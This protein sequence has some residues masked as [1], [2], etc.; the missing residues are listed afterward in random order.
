MSKLTT[1]EL[2]TRLATMERAGEDAIP[3]GWDIPD[4]LHPDYST[5]VFDLLGLPAD[6]WDHDTESGFCRDGF[7][8]YWSE[9]VEGRLAV[10]E[11][12]CLCG[13]RMRRQ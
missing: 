6:T 10:G 5:L 1:I 13:E 3:E 8:G 7:Y 2:V 12:I 9:V 4:A 11:F